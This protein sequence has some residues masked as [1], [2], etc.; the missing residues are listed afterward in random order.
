MLEGHL[1]SRTSWRAK[2]ASLIS[3]ARRRGISGADGTKL[4]HSD[5]AAVESEGKHIEERV[6]TKSRT[7]L[8]VEKISTEQPDLG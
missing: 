2:V 8:E 1:R 3:I 6:E 5:R 4:E 7:K